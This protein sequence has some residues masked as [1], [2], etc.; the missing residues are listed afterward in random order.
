M[1]QGGP[2]E[3]V[4]KN[5][6]V[7]ISRETHNRS[8]RRA[9]LTPADVGWLIKRGVKVEVKSSKIRIF[10][11][12]QYKKAKA[13]VVDRFKEATL[14]LGIKPPKVANIYKDKTYMVFSHTIKG[15]S[16]SMPL[17]KEF[18]KRRVTL[19][20]Y[21]KIT[22]LGGKR[23]IHFGRF[24][25]ICGLI[26]SLYY[27]GKKLEWKGIENPFL[28]LEP[29]Y[30]YGS[31]DE[32]IQVMRRTYNKIKRQGFDERISPFII[33]IIGQGCVS[34]GV[35]EILRLL[36]PVE[37]HPKDILKFVRRQKYVHNKMYKIVFHYQEQLRAKDGNR[38]YSKEYLKSPERFE[39]NM[40]IYLPFLSILI[41]TSYWDSRYPRMVTKEM[42]DKLWGKKNFRLEF[43]GDIS[44]DING[45]IE[46]TYKTTTRDNPVF[47]YYPKR[48]RFIPL[49]K[50]HP[51]RNKFLTGQ[52][53]KVSGEKENSLTGF[54]DGYKEK[55]ITILAV[56]N[57]PT[58]LPKDSSEDFSKQIRDYIYQ[59]ASQGAKDIP[60][61][62]T[63]PDEIRQAVITQSG[64]LT[65]K[66]N[67][68]EKYLV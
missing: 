12:E 62:T 25:G 54:I 2:R 52:A 32:I 53:D 22:D 4:K 50:V 58:E 27:L 35:Q 37:V 29:A 13:A 60:N 67:Y 47:T 31:L 28:D 45:S 68:L 16:A 61:H 44:C 65:S 43:I 15:Q 11:D 30:K 6:V 20:D 1:V 5:L 57:L 41:H 63:M 21:E 33:G 8:E 10:K 42:I 24:A 34:Q 3:T 19:I 51:V 26:D 49:E 46:P 7:G 48:K 18:I 56:D 14:I 9:P 39:S 38:F 23:L 17:L 36:N 59:I 40:D 66:F 64:R 55:G